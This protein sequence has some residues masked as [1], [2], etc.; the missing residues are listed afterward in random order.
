VV[1]AA[2]SRAHPNRTKDA[3]NRPIDAQRTLDP[4]SIVN[5]Y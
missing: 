2:Q 1:N 4:A 5:R 3:A